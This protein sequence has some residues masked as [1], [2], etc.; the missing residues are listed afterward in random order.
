MMKL[1]NDSGRCAKCYVMGGSY[2]MT[3]G[4]ELSDM[5]GRTQC[6]VGGVGGILCKGMSTFR[7]KNRISEQQS[8]QWEL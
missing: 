2:A 3:V 8:A 4:G 7:G 1:H 5:G 6:E